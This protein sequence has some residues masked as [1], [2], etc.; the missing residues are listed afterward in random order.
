MNA[1]EY[2][3]GV[4]NLMAATDW[5]FYSPELDDGIPNVP[6]QIKVWDADM[7]MI[8]V[9]CFADDEAGAAEALSYA[10]DVSNTEE[11]PEFCWPE[12]WW[13]GGRIEGWGDEAPPSQAE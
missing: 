5:P 1:S 12:A 4:Y 13:C 6:P 3:Q 10:R 9:I 8:R 2:A 7:G 11:H